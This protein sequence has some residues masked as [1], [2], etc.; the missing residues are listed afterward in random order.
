MIDIYLYR[1]D[2]IYKGIYK[3]DRYYK[4]LNGII[5]VYLSNDRYLLLYH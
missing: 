3:I 2:T 5:S 1:Y 4:S